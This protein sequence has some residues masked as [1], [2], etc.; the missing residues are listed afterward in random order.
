[1]AD[2]REQIR[3][4]MESARQQLGAA[5]VTFN[6]DHLVEEATPAWGDAKKTG[7]TVRGILIG[8]LSGAVLDIYDIVT[9]GEEIES[10]IK[11]LPD[12]NLGAVIIGPDQITVSI[13]RLRFEP[14]AVHNFTVDGLKVEF[15]DG[16]GLADFREIAA[17]VE[18][19]FGEIIKTVPG[20]QKL[21]AIHLRIV[22]EKYMKEADPLLDAAAWVD[23]QESKSGRFT[24]YIISEYANIDR[25]TLKTIAHE[26][27]HCVKNYE[28]GG[29]VMG[30]IQKIHMKVSMGPSA[31]VRIRLHRFF[32]DIEMEG[33]ARYIENIMAYGIRIMD[34]EGV[35]NAS[36]LLERRA[37]IATRFF[38]EA[39]ADDK[40]DEEKYKEVQ[41][42]TYTIGSVMIEIVR[43]AFPELTIDVIFEMGPFELVKKYEQACEQLGLDIKFSALSGKGMFD[44]K[45]LVEM[46]A[47]KAGLL[48]KVT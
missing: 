44:Y 47:A 37:E 38:L 31:D 5:K 45:G 18:K 30:Q 24:A 28:S 11:E 7:Q 19:N 2:L 21:G 36:L 3:A 25:D 15:A 8:E 6:E 16:V 40:I 32:T 10:I 34:D 29:Y 13:S 48:D 41:M 12:L 22:K 33:L 17:S 26:L 35:G 23:T 14:V 39:I 4:A 42:V 46:W 20:L 27:V 43:K 9:T 1:M